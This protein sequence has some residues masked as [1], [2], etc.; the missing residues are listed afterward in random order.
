MPP[1]VRGA[2]SSCEC[3]LNGIGNALSPDG[4]LCRRGGRDAG[5]RLRNR[6]GSPRLQNQARGVLN[7]F[8]Q[9]FRFLNAPRSEDGIRHL[10]RRECLVDD[11]GERLDVRAR[12]VAFELH[13]LMNRSCL[14]QRHQENV[15]EV[16]VSQAREELLHRL[17]AAARLLQHLSVVGL[18]GIEEE[19]RVPGGRGVDD[20]E[21]T[22]ALS[23]GLRERAKDRDFFRAGA[24]EK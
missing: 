3:V 21:L 14:R 19:Q 11:P 8:L 10:E 9:V 13:G 7:Q 20:D 6:I 5:R 24:E 2:P 4:T 23:D 17:W 18:R 22:F 16:R 15:R 1:N 12:E